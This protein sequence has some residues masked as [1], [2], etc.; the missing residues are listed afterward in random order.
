MTVSLDFNEK[1]LNGSYMINLKSAKQR[2]ILLWRK[3]KYP[4]KQ[5]MMD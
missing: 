4:K 2:N 5:I 1:G 3:P